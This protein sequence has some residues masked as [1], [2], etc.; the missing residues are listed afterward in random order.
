MP[1]LRRIDE[2]QHEGDAVE[3]RHEQP[4]LPQRAQPVRVGVRV[5][6]P[7]VER[8]LPHGVEP[9]AGGAERAA[10]EERGDAQ[11]GVAGASILR[12]Q[13]RGEREHRGAEQQH[14]VVDEQPVVGAADVVEHRVVVRPDDAH[15]QEAHDERDVDRPLVQERAGERSLAKRLLARHAQVEHEQRD[16]DGEHAVTERLDARRR[17]F[18]GAHLRVGRHNSR[19]NNWNARSQCTPCGCF[20]W[21]SRI[22]NERASATPIPP[23]R[24]GSSASVSGLAAM[25]SRGR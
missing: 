11:L 23:A 3:H 4:V 18:L 25:S 10:V 2:R 9:H 22:L 15:L 6:Q 8:V 14:E 7:R 12:E 5:H 17:G 20:S 21:G 24:T 13:R 19:S 16:D 1:R